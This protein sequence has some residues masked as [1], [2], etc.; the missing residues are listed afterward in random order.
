[1][2]VRLYPADLG[3][4]RN[5]ITL[6]QTVVVRDIWLRLRPAGNCWGPNDV[7]LYPASI[8]FPAPT[9]AGSQTNLE[10]VF[11][12]IGTAAFTEMTIFAQSFSYTAVGT[13][14]FSRLV[15]FL[16]SF[17]YSATGTSALQRGIARAFSYT[18][19]GTVTYSDTVAILLAK[20][21]TAIGTATVEVQAFFT[22]GAARAR[23]L[24]GWLGGFFSP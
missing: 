20:S 11:S 3:R 14:T 12:A 23:K 19:T 16:R 5:D 4:G 1:M 2:D 10:L 22:A 15:A 7:Q 6:R 18:A 9:V 17:S 24:R 8:V 13:S 21:I